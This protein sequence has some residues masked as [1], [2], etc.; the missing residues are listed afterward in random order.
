MISSSRF[1]FDGEKYKEASKHQ[2]EWGSSLISEFN[3][4]GME[5]ILDLGCGDGV[6]TEKISQLVPKGRVIGIDASVGMIRTAEKLKRDN[7][8]FI[9]MDM[10]NISYE[11]EFALVFSNAALHWIKNHEVLLCKCYRALKNGGKIRWGFGG[12]GNCPNLNDTIKRVMNMPLFA[13]HFIGFEWPW[14]MPKEND[15]IKL[16]ENANFRQVEVFCENADIYFSNCDE[17]IKW[18]EQPCLVPFLK[19]IPDDKKESFRSTVI[20]LMIERTKQS[21]GKCLEMFRRLNIKAVK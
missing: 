18:V 11:N 5:D 21:D 19:C 2:K 4:S 6:L 1:E 13:E 17:M 12:Y 20:E 3:F 14:Y 8:L 10:N 9:C 15:Y 16:V 7:L